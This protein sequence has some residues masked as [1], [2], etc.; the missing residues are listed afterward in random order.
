MS[1]TAS[2]VTTAAQTASVAPPPRPRVPMVGRERELALAEDL[3]RRADVGL[4][5][6]TGAGGS[7]KT[8]L[9]LAIAARQQQYFADG[10]AWVPLAQVTAA[11]QVLP[12]VARAIGVR[13]IAGDE[14]RFTLGRVLSDRALLLLLDNF[15]HVLA[16]APLISEFLFSC[17]GLKALVTSR[18][19]LHVSEEHEL[20]VL[21][22]AL[23]MDSAEV[24][25]VSDLAQIPSV[26]L[27]CQRVAAIDPAWSLTT[28]NAATVAEICRRLDGL[29]LAIELAAARVRILPPELLLERLSHRLMVL[30]EGPRDLPARQQTLRAAINWSYE[31]L[32]PSEQTVFR[33]LAV[34]QDGFSLE[35]ASAVANVDQDVVA[36]IEDTL[37][38][39]VDQHLLIRLESTAGESR[40]GMLETIREFAL[41]CLA[42]AGEME[43]IRRA[44]AEYFARLAEIAEPVLTSGKRQPWLRRLDTEQA[45]IRV[46]LECARELDSVDVGF[47][48]IGSLWLWCWLTFREARRWVEQLRVLPSASAPS[49]ARA[50]AL[51]AAAILAWGD[52]D[53]ATARRLAEQA[54]ALSRELG[55][56]RELAHALQTLGASTDGDR[57]GMEALYAEATDLVDRQGDPW[58]MALTRLRHGIASAQLG[59]TFS[60]RVHAAEAAQRFERL[61]D[62]F[63]LGRSHLQLGLAQLQ[64]G[65]LTEAR[66]N[67]EASLAAIREA[68]DWKYTG[69]ALIGL[70]SAARAVGDAA[71]GALAYTEAL[72]LCRDA[73]AAGDVPL[74]LEGLAAV[75]SALG[76]PAVAAR[77]LGA[78]ETAQA[79]GFTATFPGFEQAYRA[80]ARNVGD[81]LPPA[82]FAAELAVGRSL[83]LAETLSL[84]HGLSTILE[85]PDERT[86]SPQPVPFGG[87]SERETQVLRLVALGQSNAEIATELVLSVRTVEKHVANIYAK[88]G[89]RGRADAATY[90]LRHGFIQQ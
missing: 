43:Q 44:H 77:L 6:L 21:P 78:A 37:G 31:L 72:T 27:W 82:T 63:F 76:Q 16:A 54:V 80:T 33:R 22:L 73:G 50:N 34:F 17:P 35:A 71:A 9:A 70:G 75:A 4:L 74:C 18:A 11:D 1:S 13:E 53:T 24:Q 15:E 66:V 45:N 25:L 7:G 28:D 5:T 61:A 67:L 68:H 83:T 85:Q 84:A 38:A 29:P 12:A 57:L 89:A 87:L 52:G 8:R 69:I 51:N 60:A 30:T 64:L 49:L 55:R 81:V 79:A 14:L 3:L 88:I 47:R 59:E 32:Q 2:P 46:A 90:A 41:E 20:A 23:A 42:G 62:D 40:L 19:P 56:G 36:S 86:R 48:I 39:L 26:Q 65:E 10:V 58:W